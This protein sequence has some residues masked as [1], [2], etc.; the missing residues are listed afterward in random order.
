MCLDKT[1]IQ[2]DLCTPMFIAAQCPVAKTWERPKCPSIDEWINKM[3]YIYTR[4]YYSD[5][6]KKGIMPFE[7]TWV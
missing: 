4:E 5:I 7:A 3:W 1:I 6:K 2:K